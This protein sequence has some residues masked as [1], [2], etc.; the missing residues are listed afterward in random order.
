MNILELT[1]LT[2]VFS[3][4]RV[5]NEVSLSL[6]SGKIYGLLG[7][8]GSGKSTLMKLVS[9][10]YYK[11]DG[12]IKI[13]DQ[14]IN[15]ETKRDVVFM[16]TEDFLYKNMTIKQIG[17]FY[18]DFYSDFELNYFNDLLE[19]MM[20]DPK[21]YVSKCSSGMEAKLKIAVSL[22][23]N[24]KLYL[25]DEPLN[26]IDIVARKVIIDCIINRASDENTILISSHLIHEFENILDDVF[27]IKYG[28]IVLSGNAEEIRE[29]RN[30]SI[31]DIYMEVFKNA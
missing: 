19:T 6:E 7:P 5:V 27:F 25:L 29:S 1:N 17:D 12:T 11:T 13:L 3:K 30:K 22:S 4:T 24:T 2:K 14:Y 8:N 18:N 28:S 23:R 9:G 31:V 16:T 20:L 26:G 21:V 10:L 15:V